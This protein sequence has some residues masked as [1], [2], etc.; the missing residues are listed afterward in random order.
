M[1]TYW[2]EACG[3]ECTPVLRDVGPSADCCFEARLMVHDDNGI[4][5]CYEAWNNA[6]PRVD[7][8]CSHG[9]VNGYHEIAPLRLLTR[10]EEQELAYELHDEADA[11]RTPAERARH[12]V[13]GE[14]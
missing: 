1:T 7:F 12:R 5:Y 14:S 6:H 4:N 2:C 3:K 11:E 13:M 8:V 9:V 10:F